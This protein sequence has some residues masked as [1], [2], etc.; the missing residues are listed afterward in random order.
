V[1]GQGTGS[2]R[3]EM[4]DWSV[5]D[6]RWRRGLLV[7]V[8]TILLTAHLGAAQD[9]IV[10]GEVL[11][12]WQGNDAIQF[13][14]LTIIADG[15]QNL[16]NMAAL[17]FDDAAAA[18]GTRRIFTLTQ[19]IGRGTTNAKILVATQELA[20]LSGV[21]PDFVLP[22]GSISQRSGRVCYF[23]QN[24]AGEQQLIDCVLYGDFR[25]PRFGLGP[26]TPITPDNRS[27]VRINVSSSNR[28]DW[29]GEL[30][31]TPEN[32]AGAN[33]AL[34]TLCGDGQL[35]QGEECDGD[36]LD[37]KTC[38]SVGFSSGKLGCQQCH[39]DTSKCSFCG[40]G[41]LNGNEQCDGNEL[42]GKSCTAL[43]WSGGDLACSERC[44]LDASTCESPFFVAGV[45]G[46]RREC[47]MEW[48]I[49][50]RVG[51]PNSD[52]LAASRIRC[53]D[54]DTTCDG[55]AAI[56]TCTFRV[57]PCLGRSDARLPGC[58]PRGTREWALLTPAVPDPSATALLA[59][60]GA[61]GPSTTAGG[62]ISFAP[63]LDATLRCP[64]AVDVVVPVRGKL[65]LKARA[66]PPEGK[67]RDTDVLT[68]VCVP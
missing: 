29:I 14:E 35:S 2:V 56:G 1:D 44:K 3:N 33:V 60:V 43:G 26:P 65:K 39:F 41:A 23:V 62:T 46:G 37:G 24:Q 53:R 31:P 13:V 52:G 54:G 11:S 7:A 64:E 49:E 18:D 4:R 17:A 32:N 67:P 19:N 66:T 57:A 8:S 42:R 48:R 38:A 16:A 22:A 59:G 10:L 68:L 5:E 40:N 51:G 63:P 30:A 36:S 12:S 50:G 34:T 27:L 58:A 55:D 9:R 21:T 6:E 20:A 25:G 61:L 15:Q 45:G 28:D 47:V